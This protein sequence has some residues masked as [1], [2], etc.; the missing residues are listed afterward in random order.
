[1][2]RPNFCDATRS[3]WLEF[4]RQINIGKN[5]SKLK[6]PFLVLPLAVGE[7]LDVNERDFI[8]QAFKKTNAGSE[9]FKKWKYFRR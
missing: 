8:D 4:A 3:S 6:L 2:N 5:F 1:M 7:Q 9:I